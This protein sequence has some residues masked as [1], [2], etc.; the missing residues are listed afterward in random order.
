MPIEIETVEDYIQKIRE[1]TNFYFE[2]VYEVTYEE[3][4]NNE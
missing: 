3:G 2:I 4:L 1:I